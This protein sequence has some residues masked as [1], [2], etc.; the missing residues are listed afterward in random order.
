MN[1]SLET[2]KNLLARLNKEQIEAVTQGFGPSLIIAGAG[3]G[4]TTVLTRR[5]A[6]LLSDLNQDAH[7][8]LAVTFTNKAAAEMKQ[9]IK[10]LL[11][12]G[13]TRSLTN[14]TFHSICA[15]LLRQE[16][17]LYRTQEGWRWSPNFV[18][19]D[20]TDSVNVLK[21]EISKLNLDE[22]VYPARQIKHSISSLKNDGITHSLFTH[23]AKTHRE[24]RLAEI[25]TNYQNALA[26][27][28][29]LDFDDLI[30]IFNELLRSNP[31]VL[32]REHQR[33]RHILVDEF[34]DTNKAQYDLIRMLATGS[35]SGHEMNEEERSL[36]VVGDVDQSI[37]SWRKADFR[38]ILGFQSDFSNSR[39][40]KL[41]ENYRST[42][43]ILEVANNIIA[44]NTERLEKVLRCNRGDGA[45]VQA[46]EANDEIDE[47]YYVAEEIKRLKARGRGL[48]EVVILYRTNSQSRA[49]EEILIRNNIPY[50]LV[51]STRFYERQ[52][53]KD[54]L[55]YLKL[56]Y[57]DK[58]SQAFLR[59][60]N[61]PRRGIG[62]TS[63]ER[64]YEYAAENDIG[65]IQACLQCDEANSIP[66]KARQSLK[67]FALSV[68]RWQTIAA[69]SPVSELL[70]IVLKE[71]KY[72]ETLH[73]EARSTKDELILGRIENIQELMAVAV[74][75]EAIADESTLDA[76]LT[77]ISLVSDLDSI[78][79]EGEAI[80]LMTLHSA[81]GLEFGVVFM[82]GLEEGLF[83]HIRSL[84]S[85]TALEEERRLM[86]VGVTRAADLL[87]MTLARR[88]MIPGRFGSGGG[89][90]T[91]NFTI[92]SR[93]LKEID[94]KLLI[95]FYPQGDVETRQ[96]SEEQN[97]HS[98]FGS[99]SNKS[100]NYSSNNY[101]KNN[102][103]NNLRVFP[104]G[105][106]SNNAPKSNA[107]SSAP[108]RAMRINTSS[109][110][111]QSS[112]GYTENVTNEGY[113]L[114]K[115]GDLV[116]HNKFG[117]GEVVQVIGDKGKELYNVDFKDAGKRLLDPRFAKLNKLSE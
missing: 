46:Y 43:T 28:N 105:Q 52:E 25:Y 73:E 53:I 101:S 15:R 97:S 81:K 40:I 58:D 69:T 88:R 9:R 4:K 70:S 67:E 32:Q 1:Q 56:I 10:V 37:Y 29:A 47:A 117:L 94:S 36:M 102:D 54:T 83:P 61:V 87:Y 80:T 50:M 79:E 20:E 38:I 116:Q 93:F 57:N 110:T 84:D 17:E 85:P 27:N 21:S 33:F 96:M 23:E 64:L 98:N 77:R 2:G 103:N 55:A 65:L 8:I 82:M 99:N 66:N 108:K 34:Q 7:S 48:A 92:P 51:G 19:Y 78:K 13:R 68:R 30:L 11:G 3:S 113:E 112:D 114:L 5:I 12:E 89:G 42:A 35:V 71:S 109:G 6:F 16:I 90:F 49:I 24:S 18:I 76:F 91:S 59:I 44:N 41:E 115:V 106:N 111:S 75:F 45:K 39:F 74:E 14:G 62:K 107:H 100:N 95:G 31:T 86:Y 104:Y 26:N 63:L 22:K 60:V 72:L